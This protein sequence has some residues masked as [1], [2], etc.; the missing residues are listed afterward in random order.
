[1]NTRDGTHHQAKKWE[2]AGRNGKGT[3]ATEPSTEVGS[4]NGIHH[5][6]EKWAEV[7]RSGQKRAEEGR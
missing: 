5:R 1:M 4:R 6:A 2:E 3:R 7:G